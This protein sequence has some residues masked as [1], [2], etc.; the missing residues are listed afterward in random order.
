V[1][2]LDQRG[3]GQSD[4]PQ[5]PAYA[6]EDFTGD[7][8]AVM[9]ALGWRQ[10]VVVGHSMGGH[11]AMAFAAWYPDRVRGLVV[12]DARPVISD[13]RLV[14]MHRRGRRPLWYHPTMEAAVGAFRLLPRENTADPALLEHLA[15]EGVVQ[16][17]GG[18]VYRF[19]PTANV[20][21][22]PVDAWTLLDRIT[23]PTLIA[24]AELSPVLPREQA[25]RLATSIARATLVEIPGAYH[26]VTLDRP[27]EFAQT[28]EE[29][30][31]KLKLSDGGG[32][33]GNRAERQAAKADGAEA[34]SLHQPRQ[35][36]RAQEPLDGIG[37]IRVGLPI[38]CHHGP[39]GRDDPVEI[40]AEDGTPH[41]DIGPRDLEAQNSPAALRHPP[42]LHEPAL[43]ALE[44]A[45]QKG[46]GHGG[47]RIVRE[48][49]GKGVGGG[50]R[51][52]RVAGGA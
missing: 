9:D 30:L 12:V 19:D 41:G 46:R 20:A 45:E 44:V 49:Q 6:T 2:S 17:D 51:N 16:R 34:D 40:D 8:V 38:A 42:H 10:I 26:H 37:Q 23:A 29:F 31:G 35:L 47:K 25:T 48:G 36:R 21:R 27:K 28:L 3:H 39:D 11:N 18:W 4:W 43:E 7:L 14:L 22:K 33:Q 52:S 1:I 15:R 50:Q 13:D 32:V 24:R 5:E